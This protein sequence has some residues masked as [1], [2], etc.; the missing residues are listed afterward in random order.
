VHAWE[1][2]VATESYGAEAL[3]VPALC[4]L[5]RSS[6]GS[7]EAAAVASRDN[8]A[9]GEHYNERRD[10]G[11]RGRQD[12]RIIRLRSFNNWLKSVLINLHTQPGY[13]VL[14]L[15]CGKGGDLNKWDKSQ[16]SAYVACDTAEVSIQ[17]LA[18][19]FNSMGSTTFRPLLL[20]GDCFAVRLA[21]YLPHD[22]IFDIVSCQFAMHYAFE[23]EAR[24]R[25]MLLNVTE[26][27]R[28]GGFFV[29]TTPDSNVLVRKLRGVDGLAIG[30][31]VFRI[32]L[33]DEFSD[34]RFASVATGGSPYGIRY[35]F[36]LD[37][38]VDDCPEY[39]V[40]F[41]SLQELAREYE[42]ELVLVCNFHDFYNE[43]TSDAYLEFRELFKRM[44][45]LDESGG[46]PDDQWDAIYLYTA[47]A[48]K[49]VGDASSGAPAG[50]S[51]RQRHDPVQ[52]N[53]II[54]MAPPGDVA[55]GGC[56]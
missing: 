19:R 8:A 55:D 12:S 9:V 23:S 16:C 33:D 20:V 14:D 31:D 41:P 47:F 38:N 10:E 44:H 18:E 52:E 21:D 11:R 17:Q 32:E 50:T 22:A 46:I 7:M 40:H 4:V 13:R 28:P 26:R 54:V 15:C 30:N 37:S 49:K 24:T 29:G 5:G 27:L 1:C 2:Y 56:D 34:K 43:F 39:L 35:R 53:E 36:T 25:Q 51:R 48:F 45:V 6:S 3:N 42:L